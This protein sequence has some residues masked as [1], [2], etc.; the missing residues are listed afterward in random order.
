MGH[1]HPAAL[2]RHEGAHNAPL[3]PPKPPDSAQACLA[4]R[5]IAPRLPRAQVRRVFI[6]IAK[7]GLAADRESK[8]RA[9][10]DLQAK[11]EAQQQASLMDKMVRKLQTHAHVMNAKLH[12]ASLKRRLHAESAH[13]AV[14]LSTSDCVSKVR[15][16]ISA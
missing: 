2:P 12:F 13:A 14:V 15:S 4:P 10:R 7:A 8:V 5:L 3:P 16:H 1:L 6:E 11:Q 9:L